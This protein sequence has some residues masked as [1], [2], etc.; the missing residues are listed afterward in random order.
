MGA[1]GLIKE[2][3]NGFV[4]YEFTTATVINKY[5]IYAGGGSAYLLSCLP[6]TWQFQA[7]DEVSSTWI[8]LHSVTNALTWTVNEARE[9]SFPNASSYKKYRLFINANQG[10]IDYTGIGELEMFPMTN[11]SILYSIPELLSTVPNSIL[12][13]VDETLNGDS[14]KYEISRD[15]KTTWSQITPGI[16]TDISNQ[17]TG[18]SLV[19]KVT[20]T[21]N[22]ILNAWSYSWN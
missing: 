7:Y 9:Y 5:K 17:P 3:S 4:G 6:K 8:T 16:L 22:A 11:E 15:N 10:N 12:L 21:R 2:P 14:I 13:I 1:V 20:I 18:T 19:I